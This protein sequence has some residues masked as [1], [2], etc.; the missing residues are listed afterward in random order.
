MD[1][2]AAP[3]RLDAVTPPRPPSPPIGDDGIREALLR[4]VASPS[5]AE[6]FH[7]ARRVLVVVSDATR[8]TG[9][10]RYLPPLIDHVRAASR[11]EIRFAV[12]SGIHRRPT[13]Q[14]VDSILGPRLAAGH[15]IILHDPD[16]RSALEELGRTRAGTPVAIHAAVREQDRIVLTG[17]VGFHYYAGFSGGR[18]ALVPGLASRATVTANHL[19]AL[20][21][22]GTR[23]PL[24]RAGRLGGNP[25]H[26]DMTDG[27]SLVGP[28]L[29]INSVLGE[30]GGIERLWVGH[31]RRAHEAACRYVRAARSVKVRPR[32]L[33][34]AS[35][36][37]EPTDINLIQAHKAFE[38]GVAAVKPGG[39]FVLVARCREKAGHSDFL[40]FFRHGCEEAM[41]KALK[42]D[43]RVYRQ[44]ALS[45]FL[46]ARRCRLI[47]V[48]GLAADT[49]RLLG[50]EP[51]RDLEEAFR[52]A[53]GTVRAGSRGWVLAHGSRLLIEGDA[54]A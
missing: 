45:W 51:A 44:T 29:L 32:D 28:H 10:D 53:I 36:G 43:F 3:F 40:P 35:A 34:V 7:G 1:L 47:L 38:A 52:L 12:A 33:V 18:K 26:L 46:K 17:A 4:P 41:V 8:T 22:D 49:V 21:T 24:A 50:A 13:P 20:R 16:D 2:P 42:S 23:H 37:G 9:C 48:S 27:A 19:R 15:E 54:R 11:A 6:I 14:D 25:V 39:T 5:L 30:D 31:W